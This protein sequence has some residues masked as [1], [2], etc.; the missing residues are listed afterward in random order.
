[1]RIAILLAILWL[2][3]LASLALL[4]ANPITLNRLQIAQADF[5][6]TA[7]FDVESKEAIVEKEWKQGAR[8]ERIRIASLDFETV[9]T[10]IL[11]ILPVT[12][13]ADKT[14]EIT[15]ARLLSKAVIGPGMVIPVD[16]I[17]TEGT[18]TVSEPG[19]GDKPAIV[20]KRPG[21]QVL[22][23]SVNIKNEIEFIALSPS[24]FYRAEPDAIRQLERML[25][26][27]R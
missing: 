11:Y 26:E 20:E 14:F 12:Q 17:V 16:G 15:R 2:P 5:I 18:T 10:G 23:D 19:A 25:N 7:K 27:F 13:R 22:A 6:V 8:L 3:A 21:D 9:E 24:Y 4:T 1:M